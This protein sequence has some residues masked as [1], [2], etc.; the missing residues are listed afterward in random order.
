MTRGGSR[1]PTLFAE[2]STS[3]KEPLVHSAADFIMDM[4]FLKRFGWMMSTVLVMKPASRGVAI[5]DGGDTTA[6][7]QKM[8]GS[9]AST[10]HYQRQVSPVF[11]S[12]SF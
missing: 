11:L 10:H 4:G 8:L 1:K 6:A 3:R 9:F 5:A 7:I 12:L 2:C